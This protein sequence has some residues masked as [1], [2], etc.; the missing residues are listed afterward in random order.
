MHAAL[1]VLALVDLQAVAPVPVTMQAQMA[2]QN[3]GA[4]GGVR[5]CLAPV[6][7]AQGAHT[8]VTNVQTRGRLVS[9]VVTAVEGLA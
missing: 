4:A 9:D 5:T 6:T 3:P 7:T 2:V 1:S 8:L